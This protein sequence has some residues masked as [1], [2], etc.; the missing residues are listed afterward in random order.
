MKPELYVALA[1]V[2]ATLLG[3]LV[4]WIA[5]RRS[6]VRKRL[7]YTL[8]TERL[9]RRASPVL[10]KELKVI[11][12]DEELKDP[13]LIIIA[14]ANTGNVAVEDVLVDV[15]IRSDG[16][17]LPGYFVRIPAG[18]EKLW[19]IHKRDEKSV[20]VTLEHIN[21][22]QVAKIRFLCDQQQASEPVVAC[23]MP[24]VTFVRASKSELVGFAEVVA[25]ALEAR[26]LAR[27]VR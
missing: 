9:L 19:G 8:S 10:G 14:I 22:G 20:Q 11:Y 23:A 1:G 2:L 26:G 24:N 18:Y 4:T 5:T 25:Y 27:R 17:L 12:K 7:A 21:P 13:T 6:V 16:F 15:S 3:I